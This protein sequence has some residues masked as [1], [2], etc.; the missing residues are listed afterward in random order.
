MPVRACGAVRQV[1]ASS[2]FGLVLVLPLVVALSEVF[3]A[4]P[5]RGRYARSAFAGQP[6]QRRALRSIRRALGPGSCARWWWCGGAGDE[7][8]EE[9]MVFVPIPADA[10]VDDVVVNIRP[11]SLTI[12]VRGE[13]PVLDGPLW[14]GIKADE[15]GWVI[16]QERGQRCVIATLIKRDVWIDYDYLLKSHA[17]GAAGDS[18]LRVVQIQIQIQPCSLRHILAKCP[19]EATTEPT[20]DIERCR[21]AVRSDLMKICLLSPL[22]AAS[23]VASCLRQTGP[24]LVQVAVRNF[25]DVQHTG[26][27][28]ASLAGA[29]GSQV[30][31]IQPATLA[32][33]DHGRVSTLPCLRVMELNQSFDMNARCPS[34]CPY[35]SLA[36][37]LGFCSAACVRP[38]S[39]AA[40]NPDAP[41]E[42]ASRGICR[43][44]QVDGCFQP[45]LDGTD[46][47]ITCGAWY[48]LTPDGQCRARYMWAAWTGLCLLGALACA[49]VAYVVDLNLRGTVNPSGLACGLASRSM[50]KYRSGPQRDLWPLT[51]NLCV[52]PVGGPGLLLYFNFL[53]AVIVWSAAIG[54][55]WLIMAY[56][57]DQDLLILGRKEYGTPYR[58]C[59]LVAWGFVTQQRLMW[60]KLSFLLGVYIVTF[61]ACLLHGVRQR[62]LFQQSDVKDTMKA[63]A[64]LVKGLPEIRAS[65]AQVEAELSDLVTSLAGQPV[66]GVSVCWNFSSQQEQVKA[67][68]DKNLPSQAVTASP[69]Q[70]MESEGSLR[71]AFLWAE[72]I[73]LRFLEEEVQTDF[74][75]QLLQKVPSSAEAFVVFET[76]SSRDSA[77]ATLPGTV[78]FR[79]STLRFSAA[80]HEPRG[81]YWQNYSRS[82]VRA[83]CWKITKGLFCIAAGLTTW[84]CVF[85]LPYVWS[86]L[87]FNYEGGRQPGLIY[88]LSFSVIVVV[89]NA[90]MYE[91]C[92]RVSDSVGFKY[93][94][95]R[96]ACYMILYLVSVS[97]NIILDLV[98]TYQMS[99]AVMVH[100]GFRTHDGTPLSK[101]PYFVQRFEAYAI[102]RAMGQ[103]LYEYAFPSTFLVPFVCEPLVTVYGLLRVGILLVRSHPEM[104]PM[105]AT[106]L[107]SANDFEFGRYADSLLNISLAVMMFFFPGGYTH[108]IFLMLAVCQVL[109]PFLESWRMNPRFCTALLSR[110]AKQRQADLA[111]K[112]LGTMRSSDVKLNVYHCSSVISA[113]EKVNDWRAALQ[114]LATMV[115][116]HVAPNTLS[117]NASI[118][119]C[120]KS[121]EWQAALWLLQSMRA[122]QAEADVISYNSCMSACGKAA[123]WR[124]A[125]NLLEEL[126]QKDS[127]DVISFNA[128][129]TACEKGGQWMRAL[130]LL[131]A[132]R[133]NQLPNVTTYNA[134]ISACEK[135]SCAE[136]AFHL[137]DEMMDLSLTPD[138]ISYSAVVS[139][140]EK[141]WRWQDALQVLTVMD[142]QLILPNLITFN[143]AISSCAK[144]GRWLVALD[145]F[146]GMAE[147]ALRADVISYNSLINGFSIAAD[148]QRAL[149]SLECMGHQRLAPT[150]ITVNAAMSACDMA[151]H[152]ALSIRMYESLFQAVAP[153]EVSYA[154]A[155]K[156]YETLGDWPKAQG[157]LRAMRQCKIAPSIV[158]YG[159]VLQAC[160]AAAEHLQTR[161]L[162]EDLSGLAVQ[163]C[164]RIERKKGAYIY[165]LDHWRI[166]RVVPAATFA[167]MQVD[168]WCQAML[169]PSCGLLA[170][171]LVFKGNCQGVGY[172]MEAQ[173]LILTCVAAGVLHTVVHVLLLLFLVPRLANSS[174]PVTAALRPSRF[175][176]VAAEEPCTWFSANPVHCLRSKYIH[177]HSP[178]CSFF[179]PGQEQMVASAKAAKAEDASTFELQIPNL[180]RL[181][182]LREIPGFLSRIVFRS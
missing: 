12:G 89:G 59:V 167:S 115:D 83:K 182:G 163:L 39:C 145:L 151:G 7:S 24:L 120:E 155:T 23:A 72:K 127:P 105:L 159:S 176:D 169:A 138:V 48:D 140:C 63:F 37:D 157:V 112:V 30:E 46:R 165:L 134:T 96:E 88:N 27:D 173:H 4:N 178:P 18:R 80:R 168:W 54:F 57:V 70:E 119:A 110:L 75:Q 158:C 3:T 21:H 64:A 19:V 28:A 31:A 6:W 77:L 45:S 11:T 107:L 62:C 94:E 87:T 152:A 137:L 74:A 2:F 40:F 123:R 117:Y 114:L 164:N 181:Q 130:K 55:G 98:M 100:M 38:S 128:A 135:G 175:E 44:A 93:K 86:V 41:V 125:V 5:L 47:C 92:A 73:F 162:L 20:R 97:L 68:L 56:V 29:A 10:A 34:E 43:G 22:T 143:A 133:P 67:L 9:I 53:A 42:D 61:L 32:L 90:S 76:R 124:E 33:D 84:G 51:T 91:I 131:H 106:A 99:F 113:L 60:A 17:E 52:T 129:I 179:V 142:F 8:E 111:Q 50:Q 116:W 122:V 71:R 174:A 78:Q 154:V 141:D 26:L 180:P 108:W 35:S 13:M 82:S 148:W 171:C 150:A 69:S 14:K 153:N 95:T 102:Q 118:S 170:A 58:N 66:V 144:A 65:E 177:G 166:L 139:A 146:E 160:A 136:H 103:N 104:S 25:S 15:S 16:D 85:Y 147:A 132:M 172:C 1:H 49:L 109:H 79:G 149:S 126:V 81:I 156:A 101:L 36:P 161:D 121:A